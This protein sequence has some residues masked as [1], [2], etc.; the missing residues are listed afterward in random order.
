LNKISEKYFWDLAAE[1]GWLGGEREEFL[2]D[3]CFNIGNEE[4][5]GEFLKRLGK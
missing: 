5:F 2:A 1:I 3:F 4:E